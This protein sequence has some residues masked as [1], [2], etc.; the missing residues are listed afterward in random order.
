MIGP[1]VGAKVGP[2]VGPAVGAAADE[3]SASAIARD[4]TSN[5][6]VP[7]NVSEWTALMALAGLSTGNPSAVY[8]FQ[9]ASGNP[10][11]S[12][13]TFTLT[14]SGT[15]LSYQNAVTGWSRK[16]INTTSAGTGALTS[17]AAGLP[18]PATTSVLILS[19]VNVSSSV[20]A[21]IH[22]Y[23]A[24]A[25][26]QAMEATVTPR[27]QAVSGANT[28]VGTVSPINAVRPLVTRYNFTA[29]TAMGA[30]DQEKLVPT[31]TSTTTKNLVYGNFGRACAAAQYLYSAVFFGAAAEL[32]DA[33]VKT[34]LTTL[35][36]SIPW[37]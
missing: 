28:A 17:T 11:D 31:F 25:T 35:G 30:S 37:T 10:A 20:L 14:A 4:A 36:W 23:G 24:V 21:G 6:Y 33:Q 18:D 7:A 16:A 8:G 15:G 34:L 29:S 32:T 1:R 26:R 13:G 27:I 9:D 5:I 22:G 19:Y 2:R 3:L 12:V